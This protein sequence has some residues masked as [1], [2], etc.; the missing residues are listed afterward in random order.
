LGTEK[1]VIDSV[2]RE[3]I[4]GALQSQRTR[5]DHLKT[6]SFDPEDLWGRVDGDM[7]LLR[8]LVE[9]FAAECPRMLVRVEEA[10]AQGSPTDLERASHKIK[11]SVLQFS[12]RAA[13]SL[14]FE[15]EEKGRHG[16]VAGAETLLSRL[17][18][19]IDRLQA[20]LNS[21]ACGDPAR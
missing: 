7:E 19:E 12:A 18:Q 4:A 6:E 13:A 2:N 20:A 1:Q 11:G 14:A 21:M 17:R 3:I 15:L 16:L 5:C 10:I 9:V 8:E